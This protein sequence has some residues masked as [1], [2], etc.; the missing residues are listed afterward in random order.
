MNRATGAAKESA[1]A[2]VVN[3]MAQQ[4]HEMMSKMEAM[5]ANMMAMRGGMMNS[6]MGPSSTCP[7]MQGTQGTKAPMTGTQSKSGKPN[8]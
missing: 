6:A 5:G 7:C 8:S 4:R 1:M 3:E 2:A